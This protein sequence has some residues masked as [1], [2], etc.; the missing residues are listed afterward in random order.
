[1]TDYGSLNGN[2]TDDWLRTLCDGDIVRNRGSGEAYIV[3]NNEGGQ[4]VAVRSITLTNL[5]EWELAFRSTTVKNQ[6][7]T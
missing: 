7:G 6:E 5:Q 4:V 2:S 1:M 3:V